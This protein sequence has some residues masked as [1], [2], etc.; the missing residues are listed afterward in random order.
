MQLAA[1][2]TG[3]WRRDSRCQVL[4][5]G[6][7]TRFAPHPLPGSLALYK[8]DSAATEVL[9]PPIL[10]TCP[11]VWNH[12]PHPGGRVREASSPPTYYAWMQTG[13][14]YSVFP[15]GR[16]R[17][18]AGPRCRLP[19]PRGCPARLRSRAARPGTV[20]A[21]FRKHCWSFGASQ[22]RSAGDRRELRLEAGNGASAVRPGAVHPIPGGFPPGLAQ[23]A[24]PHPARGSY[25]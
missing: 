25:G 17:L 3:C 20:R 1:Y 12:Q 6:S 18:Q 13:R 9:G 5:A 21:G 11:A 14:A 22:N 15:S 8:L 2:T 23:A 19:A 24:A 10:S 7:T 4:L 16:S